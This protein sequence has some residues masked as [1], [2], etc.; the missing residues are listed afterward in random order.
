MKRF[1]WKKRFS[2]LEAIGLIGIAVICVSVW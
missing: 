2:L 1:I